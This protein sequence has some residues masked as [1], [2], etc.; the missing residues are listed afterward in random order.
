[1]SNLTKSVIHKRQPGWTLPEIV[2]V[3][4][5]GPGLTD[6]KRLTK[7][8]LLVWHKPSFRFTKKARL[9]C[10]VRR[11]SAEHF[12][13]LNWLLPR[14]IRVWGWVNLLNFL[15]STG[16]PHVEFWPVLLRRSLSI[17]KT[18]AIIDWGLRHWCW[19]QYL[20]SQYRYYSAFIRQWSDY[21]D[22]REIRFF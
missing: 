11:L 10:K 9:V 18:I 20:Q 8:V 7:W 19:V 12:L 21:A 3:L 4:D 16:E 22:E 14:V 5:D 15:G 17:D 2:C 1:M 6:V 13:F